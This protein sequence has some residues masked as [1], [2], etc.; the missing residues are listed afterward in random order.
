MVTIKYPRASGLLIVDVCPSAARNPD[1]L[2]PRER[3]AAG[4]ARLLWA[5]VLW[6]L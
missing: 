4:G 1:R 5:G 3:D 6:L 2:V